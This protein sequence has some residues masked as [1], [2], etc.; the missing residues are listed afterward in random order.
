MY[1]ELNKQKGPKTKLS[2]KEKW[3]KNKL[4]LLN[5]SFLDSILGL[6]KEIYSELEKKGE[7]LFIVKKSREEFREYINS[8]CMLGVVDENKELLGQCYIKPSESSPHKNTKLNFKNSKGFEIGGILVKKSVRGKK[9]MKVMLKEGEESALQ[10]GAKYMTAEVDI[11]NLYSFRVLL[12]NGY[13]IGNAGICKE[14]GAELYYLFKPLQKKIKFYKSNEKIQNKGNL[15]EIIGY[16]KKG[17]CITGFDKK[18]SNF[19]I[20][21]PKLVK[22]KEI[23]TSFVKQVIGV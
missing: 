17:Y 19:Y 11:R 22:E 16:L 7:Q 8:D 3:L 15:D 23:K 20:S 4:S 6:Q 12:N 5:N 18:T 1:T 13:F 2:E 10:K 9:L 21:K 14:D